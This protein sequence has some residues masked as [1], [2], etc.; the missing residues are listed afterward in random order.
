MPGL[1]RL[2]TAS[3]TNNTIQLIAAHIAQKHTHPAG[4]SA[5]L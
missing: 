5:A 3:N 4:G 1:T 2:L